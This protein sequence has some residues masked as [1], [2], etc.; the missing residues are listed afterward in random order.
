[1]T[2]NGVKPSSIILSL[3][4][5]RGKG[6]TWELKIL[7]NLHFEIFGLENLEL[8]EKLLRFVCN[9]LVKIITRNLIT[10]LCMRH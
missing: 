7:N 1:M 5:G 2:T 3:V 4:K 10:I 8:S 9:F 6:K